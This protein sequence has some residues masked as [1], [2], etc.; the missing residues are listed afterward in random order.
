MR[1]R[2]PGQ[3]PGRCISKG[4]GRR[5]GGHAGLLLAH[6]VDHA[7]DLELGRL[8]LGEELVAREGGLEVDQDPQGPGQAL[9]FLQLL[10]LAGHLRGATAVRT[11]R[12]AG[13]AEA[14]AGAPR[15]AGLRDA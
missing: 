1:K 15:L 11:R 14:P 2:R 7:E 12:A 10:E 6:F 5:Q 13:D 4:G 8:E 3:V 9:R